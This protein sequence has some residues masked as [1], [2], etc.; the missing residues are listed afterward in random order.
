VAR[1]REPRH[2]ER[3][4][5]ERL[6]GKDLDERAGAGRP[7]SS[8]ARQAQRSVEAYLRGGGMPRWM[9]RVGQID[10]RTAREHARL[11]RA[12]AEL[13]EDCAGDRGAFAERWTVLAHEWR[14]DELNELVAQHNEWYPIE[15]QLPVDPRTGEYVRVGGRSYRREPLGPDWVLERF[16]AAPIG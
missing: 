1:V 10:A 16:P 4:V 9:E 12:H 5:V 11:A 2:E 14:F 6:V 13:E 15:R 3:S 7:L 8:R